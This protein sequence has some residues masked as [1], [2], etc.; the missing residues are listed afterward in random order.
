M[1]YWLISSFWNIWNSYNIFFRCQHFYSAH[2]QHTVIRTTYKQ[3]LPGVPAQQQQMKTEVDLRGEFQTII[4]LNDLFFIL[5]ITHFIVGEVHWDLETITPTRAF[6]G[7]WCR[8]HAFQCFTWT[9]RPMR[10]RVCAWASQCERFCEVPLII[11]ISLLP[12]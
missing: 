9:I 10:E 12:P 1:I 8:T 4:F 11:E 2:T 6:I 5:K 7:P 3:L